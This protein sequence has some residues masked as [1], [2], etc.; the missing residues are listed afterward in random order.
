[1][2]HAETNLADAIFNR[3]EEIEKEDKMKQGQQLGAAAG[4]PST[5]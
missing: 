3:M 2:E 4:L 5:S 1:M